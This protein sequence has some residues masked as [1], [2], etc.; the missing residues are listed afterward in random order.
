MKSSITSLVRMGYCSTVD[1]TSGTI[2]A[3]FPDRE[4]NVTKDLPVVCAGG[5]GASNGMPS[6]GDTV[7]CLMFG[8]GRSDG[9]CLGIIPERVP[10]TKATEGVYFEDGSYVY[11]DQA[12]QKLMIKANSGVV[13]EG[14]LTVSGT[15]SASNLGGG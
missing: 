13:I 12:V 5:F 11:Y 4:D 7:V 14:D 6:P 10:G 8:N 1:F 3:T 2:T 9:V 15:V